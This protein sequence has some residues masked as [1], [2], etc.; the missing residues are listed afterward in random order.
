[1]APLVEAVEEP[2]PEPEVVVEAVEVV[3]EVAEEETNPH[4][5]LKKVRS[6][7]CWM[8]AV[9]LREASDQCTYAV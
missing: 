4:P 2:Q 8:R 6:W 5:P 9:L 3:E 7:H 1:L